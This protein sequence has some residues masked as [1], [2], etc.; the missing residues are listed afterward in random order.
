MAE[1]SGLDMSISVFVR[2]RE[3]NCVKYEATEGRFKI[4]VALRGLADNKVLNEF[5]DKIYSSLNLYHN[6]LH[7]KPIL[8]D[9]EYTTQAGITLIK[10]YRDIN[11]LSEG[12]VEL[13]V[14]MLRESFSPL[15]IIDETND[16]D[17]EEK[18][19]REIKRNLL[20]NPKLGDANSKNFF[21]YRDHGTM[22]VFNK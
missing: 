5:V 12:E 13:F 2:F 21:G 22:F 4:E 17:S 19:A 3:L 7:V 1:K 10:F 14:S 6:F 18:Y 15:L 20:H 16:L 9:V 8:L 11:S